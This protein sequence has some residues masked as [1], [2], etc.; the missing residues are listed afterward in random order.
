MVW[1]DYSFPVAVCSDAGCRTRT[2]RVD[3]YWFCAACSAASSMSTMRSTLRGYDVQRHL[4]AQRMKLRAMLPVSAELRKYQRAF[5][6]AG[7]RIR[8]TQTP[9]VSVCAEGCCLRAN[10]KKAVEAVDA[11][12]AADRVD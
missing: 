12:N 11:C 2:G 6:A 1:H 10:F 7:G 5:V 4:S 8:T 3:N 9:P